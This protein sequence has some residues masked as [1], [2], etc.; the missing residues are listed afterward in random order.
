MR[1]LILLRHA[2][3]ETDAPTGKDHDRRLEERGRADAAAMAEWLAE[4]QLVPDQ[5][6]VSTAT[7]TRQ[8]WDILSELFP[9]AEPQ[10][11]HLPELYSASAAQLLAAVHEVSAGINRL[12]LVGHNPGLQELALGL[13]CGTNE[14]DRRMLSGNMPTSAI[15]VIDFPIADWADARFGTGKLQHFV[16]PKILRE[17][18]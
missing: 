13:T 1:R 9:G 14:G 2:K 16:S 4:Q 7:R 8:T 3:T 18:S 10:V 15:A 11:E 6:L 5:V 12:M 17:A